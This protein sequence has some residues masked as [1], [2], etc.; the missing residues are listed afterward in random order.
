MPSPDSDNEVTVAGSQAEKDEYDQMGMR[1]P[2]IDK[3]N[4]T[5]PPGQ[6]APMGSEPTD[7]PDEGPELKGSNPQQ[8]LDPE[9]NHSKG[10]LQGIADQIKDEGTPL[11]SEVEAVDDANI[12]SGT[13]MEGNVSH[14]E[15]Y[16]QNT[17]GDTGME[18]PNPP[19]SE[20]GEPDLSDVLEEGLNHHADGIQR[21][22]VIQ[23][24]SQALLQFQAAKHSLEMTREQNPQLYE[25]SV[26]MLK[27]MIEMATLLG[28]GQ[29]GAEV[30]TGIDNSGKQ[31]QSGQTESNLGQEQASLAPPQEEQNDEWHDPFPKHPDHGGE[32]KPGHSPP[33]KPPG[34]SPQR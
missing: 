23:I 18:G 31:P 13:E 25:A 17:P 12:P 32:P 20:E 7:M 22:K 16:S 5:N 8:P 26:S 3:P 11:A 10:A 2:I 4:L 6:N 21:E 14:P 19:S 29:E 15:G 9:D 24:V 1:P 27:A 33:S 34:A 28:L 30:I